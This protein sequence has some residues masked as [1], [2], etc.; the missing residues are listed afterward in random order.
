MVFYNDLRNLHDE[1]DTVEDNASNA[2]AALSSDISERFGASL[3]PNG[4]LQRIGRLD[5]PWLEG[6]FGTVFAYEM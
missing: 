6:H 1:I 5:A 2:R 4:G 3:Y